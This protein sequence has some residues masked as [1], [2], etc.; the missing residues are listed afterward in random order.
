MCD[1]VLKEPKFY[2][3]FLGTLRAFAKTNFLVSVCRAINHFSVYHISELYFSHV[4]SDSDY[5]AP[6]RRCARKHLVIPQ[7]CENSIFQVDPLPT[8]FSLRVKKSLIE[9]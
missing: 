5:E 9:Q 4:P 3:D 2:K 1:V 6:P 8:A 7:S